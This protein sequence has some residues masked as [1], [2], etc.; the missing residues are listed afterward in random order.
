MKREVSHGVLLWGETSGRRGASEA[1]SEP[2]AEA[3]A[4]FGAGAQ[5]ESSEDP[6]ALNSGGRASEDLG[7][8]D[9]L[10]WYLGP[11]AVDSQAWFKML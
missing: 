4:G 10:A 5:S 9:S 7:G 3:K 6:G 2:A 1:N 8:K 11:R